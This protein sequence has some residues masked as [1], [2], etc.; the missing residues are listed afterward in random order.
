M[1]HRHLAL[2]TTE[3]IPYRHGLCKIVGIRRLEQSHLNTP[4]L[5]VVAAVVIPHER[6]GTAHAHR[7]D[8][9]L[10]VALRDTRER[11]AHAS[12]PSTGEHM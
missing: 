1:S 6:V 9:T 12:Q 2:L 4:I 5:R 7:D 10:R 8:E 3:P 11:A